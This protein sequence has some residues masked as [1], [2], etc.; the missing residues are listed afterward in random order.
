ML[1]VTCVDRES[2]KMW[3]AYVTKHNEILSA[4]QTA[5]NQYLDE[6]LLDRVR[7]LKEDKQETE[8]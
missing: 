1:C 8:Q 7:K 2:T 5:S 4:V 3:D 6:I